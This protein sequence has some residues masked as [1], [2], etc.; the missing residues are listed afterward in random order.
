MTTERIYKKYGPES[1]FTHDAVDDNWWQESAFTGWADPERGIGGAFRLGLEPNHDGKGRVTLWSGVTTPDHAI[2]H[3][4]ERFPYTATSRGERSWSAGDVVS[5]AYDEANDR[6]ARWTLRDEGI[7]LDLEIEDLHTPVALFPSSGWSLKERQAR[8]HLEC[9]LRVRGEVTLAG[10]RYAVDCGGYR[11]HSWGVRHWNTLTAHRW[12]TGTLDNGTSF[13]MA[14]FSGIDG[15]RFSAGMIIDHATDTAQYSED[16]DCI[17]F[18]EADGCSHRGGVSIMRM[19]DGSEHKFEFEPIARAPVAWHEAVACLDAPC[20]VR[21]G[22]AQGVG[23]LESN[24]NP[25]QGQ[26][27]PQNLVSATIENGLYTKAEQL[28]LRMPARKLLGL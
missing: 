5:F 18:M 8:D 24:T 12:M 22:S 26:V 23:I 6:L 27:K 7:T 9:G 4:C 1:R 11:D 2:Y 21:S 15:S 14:V 17:V 10:R 20:K 3:R 13:C 25:Q 19:P 28:S 16:I